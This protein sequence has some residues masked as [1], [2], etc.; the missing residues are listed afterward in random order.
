MTDVILLVEDN[1]SDEKLAVLAFERCGVANDV[2]VVR[3][4]AAALDYLLG[5]REHAGQRV[6]PTV[7]LLDLKLPRTHGL[8]VLR[9]IRADERTTLLP[10]V[11]LT[12]SKEDEDVL[13]HY[14]VG[15][16]AYVRKPLDFDKFAEA[17]KALGLFS[18]GAPVAPEK[19]S[20]LQVAEEALRISEEHLRDALRARDEFL[21]VA[22]QEL[23]T[24]LTSLTLQIASARQ[25]LEEHDAPIPVAKLEATLLRASLLVTRLTALIKGFLTVAR[26]SPGRMALLLEQSDLRDAV[27]TALAGVRELLARSGSKLEVRSGAPILGNWERLT[28][29]TAIFNLVSNAVQY[30]QGKPITIDVDVQADRARLVVADHGI[31]ISRELQESI[32]QSTAPHEH[33]GRFGLGLW[34]AHEIIE[35]HGGTIS[36]ASERGPGSTFTVLLP[37]ARKELSA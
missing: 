30:G 8:E 19:H 29:D 7:V 24:P 12:T 35:A 2:I 27:D 9:R 26:L 31:G 33:F 10:V 13:R 4:G 22:S 5:T 1:T 15:A 3:D 25:R 21:A 17:A 36:V 18:S 32:F 23:K 14:S 6:L 34:V 11:V 28:L 20:A 16:N 37:L